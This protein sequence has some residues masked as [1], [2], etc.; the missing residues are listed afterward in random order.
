MISKIEKL[1]Y[2]LKLLE[3]KVEEKDG[4][5]IAFKKG[6]IIEG[7]EKIENEMLI[8]GKIKIND[9]NLIINPEEYSCIMKT[10]TKKHIIVFTPIL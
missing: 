2:D 6:F 10:D 1:K 7:I 4:N 9:Y 8:G 5:I 3:F